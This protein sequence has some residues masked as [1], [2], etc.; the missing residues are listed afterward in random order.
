MTIMTAIS[1]K[2]IE[3][4]KARSPLAS[5]LITLKGEL[6]TK[7][8]GF[9]PPRD[10]TEDEI[11]ASVKKTVAT[12]KDNIALFEARNMEDAAASARAEVTLLES[13]LPAQMAD[14][15][16]RDFISSRIAAGANLGQIMADLKSEKAGL[17]DGKAASAI[18]RELLA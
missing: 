12:L 18:A 3:L 1:A 7:Q 15:E 8:K 14:D 4:R 9:K 13:F 11:I 10:L 6:E 5:S 16:L 2:T 17:Y